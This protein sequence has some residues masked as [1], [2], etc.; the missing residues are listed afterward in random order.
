MVYH[1]HSRAFFISG[2]MQYIY[3]I[4]ACPLFFYRA[5]DIFHKNL[6][7]EAEQGNGGEHGDQGPCRHIAP[8]DIILSNHGIYRHGQCLLGI[9]IDVQHGGVHIVPAGQEH[10]DEDR[11]A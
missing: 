3:S 6:F 1:A 4:G 2:V 8:V 5:R 11:K 7:H 9:G 10:E